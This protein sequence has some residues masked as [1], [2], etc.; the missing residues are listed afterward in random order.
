VLAALPMIVGCGAT[1]QERVEL[2]LYLA[3]GDGTVVQTRDGAELMLTRAELAFGPLYLCPGNQAGELCDT[4]RLEWLDSSLIDLLDADW[5]RAGRLEG[6]SGPVRSWMYDLGLP[7]TLTSQQPLLSSAAEK[8]GGVSLRV[9]GSAL[10]DSVEVAF[11]LSLVVRQGVDTERGVPVIRKSNSDRF[12]HDVG[13]NDTSLALR[14]E[15]LPWFEGID[16]AT[17]VERECDGAMPSG[18]PDVLV[19]PEDSQ[20]GRSV[21]G[22]ITA[23]TRPE[24]EWNVQ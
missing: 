16:F 23:G 1:G 13:A 21:F 12:R 7:S 19:V 18:C 20:T 2:D 14:F 8:L 3:G 17:L 9:A 24:F 22:A 11:E 4:A 6:V 10:V 15:P 5:K